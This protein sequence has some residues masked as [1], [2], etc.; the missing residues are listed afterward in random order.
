M[1]ERYIVALFVLVH[2]FHGVDGDT[3][4]L[5]EKVRTLQDWL[6]KKPLMNLNMERWRNLVRSQP[7]NYSMF[8]MFTALSPGVNCPICK[9]AY[10]EF[11]ILANSFRYAY[12]EL[13]QAYFAIVDYEEA[14]N[15][16]QQMNL[17]TAPVLYHFG[18]KLT[19]K[20]KPEQMD[21]QRHGIDA[22]AM[23]RFIAEHTEIQIRVL[24]PP[25]YAA[26]V[27]V[28]LLVMLILGLLYMK[29]N[30]LEFLYNRTSWGCVCL[31]IVFVFMSGQMW[32]HIRGP[33]FVM[34]NPNTRETSF[35]HGSTQFQLISETY[36]VA[37]LYAAV[38]L[39]FILMNDPLDVKSKSEVMVFIGLG[40]VAVFFS[41]L[42]SIFRSKSQCP[43]GFTC[44][45]GTLTDAPDQIVHVCCSTL[46]MS[47][48]D[49]LTEA[50]LTPSQIPYIP[51]V[52]L[53]AIYIVDPSTNASSPP[54]HV[55]DEVIALSYPNYVTASIA[56]LTFPV[57]P[58]GGGFLHV[59]TLID[60]GA[61]P[62]AILLTANVLAP[63]SVNCV[64]SSQNAPNFYYYLSNGTVPAGSLSYRHQY[65][66]LVFS[67][68]NQLQI[69]SSASFGNSFTP[70]QS[71]LMDG[72]SGNDIS[73][74]FTTSTIGSQLG[75]PLAGS[76]LYASFSIKL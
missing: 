26:P 43:E 73:C 34:T 2:V 11:H 67:T 55:G 50:G 52:K 13:K 35:I 71:S 54:I 20:K 1:W 64:V 29:R 58:V 57:P 74:F 5:D 60:A 65:V 72:C 49:W 24:R 15:I 62:F 4:S 46:N 63:A 25:N 51:L 7:R 47:I 21:F 3:I 28:L 39:G 56:A 45:D 31:C 38:T 76:L 42:L 19:G 17:N 44:R 6:H 61:Y 32:N 10:D 27:V 36:I 37:V 69:S 59:L 9:P 16:F 8:V 53:T 41:L 33:P 68:P 66:I 14:P 23:G 48:G 18:P 75:S 40:L 12:P 30:N 70:S 22:D